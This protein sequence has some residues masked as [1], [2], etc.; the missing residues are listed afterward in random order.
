MKAIFACLIASGLVLTSVPAAAQ[1]QNAYEAG[2]AARQG[3]RPAEA[4]R[5][6]QRWLAAHPDDLDAKLQIA[7]ADLAL[8][9]LAAAQTGFEAVLREAPEY[10]DA[11]DG[12][13]AVAAR[14]GAAGADRRTVVSLEGALSTLDGPARDW[15]EVAAD[16]EFPVGAQSSAGGRAAYY[17]RFGLSDVELVG[18]ATLHPSDDVWLRGFVGGTPNADFRPELEFGGGIDWRLSRE[19][20]TVLSLDGAYQKF[21][22][23]DVVTINPGLVQYVGGGRGW[24]TLR[25]I[26]TIA[27]GGNL[28]VGALVRADYQPAP[29]WRVFAGASNGPDTDLGVV[30]RVT[31][32]FGGFEAPL[33]SHL[34]LTA[35]IGREWRDAGSDRSEFRLGMK[36]RF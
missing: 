3:G 12:L 13:A 29:A 25:G 24:I 30:T 15:V 20:A 2:V 27:D 19:N 1:E 23:Q 34:G 28:E 8:G 5:L 18:R 10:T 22:L 35:S 26:G 31:A 4:R 32:V 17:R 9:N 6:L 14:R 33:G 36:A 16:L 7:Y 21:P 11:R